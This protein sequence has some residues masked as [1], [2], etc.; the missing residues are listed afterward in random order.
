MHLTRDE[1][2]RLEVAE[3]FDGLSIFDRGPGRGKPSTIGYA[4]VG[5]WLAP[6]PRKPRKPPKPREQ[7]RPKY[8]PEERL[9]V[10]AAQENARYHA[11][12][13]EEKRERNARQYAA[14]RARPESLERTRERVRV[15]LAKQRAEGRSSYQRMTPEQ[16]RAQNAAAYAAKKADPAKLER[17]RAMGREYMRKKRARLRAQA[18][19]QTTATSRTK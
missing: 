8:T 4:L 14:M 19:S 9:R 10:R 1:E 12:T 13:V 15:A 6:A 17:K 2:R 11:L 5:S 7:K 3:L 18:H 16:R